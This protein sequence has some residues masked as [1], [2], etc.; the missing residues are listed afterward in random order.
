MN[1][2]SDDL[3]AFL[4]NML[5]I[6]DFISFSAVNWRLRRLA[7]GS[8]RDFTAR[9]NMSTRD[10]A[11][12]SLICS[13]WPHIIGVTTFWIG[14]SQ[15]AAIGS[16]KRLQ[17][18]ELLE[19]SFNK[20]DL[21]QFIRNCSAT[22]CKF[23]VKDITGI[24]T[25]DIVDCLAQCHHLSTL[26]LCISQPTDDSDD[27]EGQWLSLRL[28]RTLSSYSSLETLT[29]DGVGINDAVLACLAFSRTLKCFGFN[30]TTAIS[31]EGLELLE[32]CQALTRI[33]FTFG[34]SEDPNLDEMLR[35][36]TDRASTQRGCAFDYRRRNQVI[37]GERKR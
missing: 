18:I 24:T 21:Q 8:Y 2:L 4:A 36:L 16:L 7:T 10:P 29:L 3:I 27:D 25:D 17:K 9:V 32:T 15:L 20:A 35:Q 30:Y 19:C 23:T 34:N 13:A 1:N 37:Y 22:I 5:C 31:D 33:F 12:I 14:H 11:A 6:R 28:A 26:D